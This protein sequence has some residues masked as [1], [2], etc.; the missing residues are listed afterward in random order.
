MANGTDD[1]RV[2]TNRFVLWVPKRTPKDILYD[3]FVSS[4]IKESRWNYMREMY[5]V[6]KNKW[7]F[8]NIS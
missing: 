6:Y 7:I 1:G 5:E 8:P 3:K 4:F 2:V